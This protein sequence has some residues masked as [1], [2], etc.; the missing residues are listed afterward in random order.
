MLK[1]TFLILAALGSLQAQ[2]VIVPTPE[3][4][5]SP[6]GETW[7]NYNVMQSYEFGYRFAT[8]G[9]DVGEYRSDVNYG[10]GIRLFGTNL[11]FESK[12]GHGH[13]FDELLLNTTGLGN[14]PYQYAMLRVQKNGWY[15]YD[16]TW[17]LSDYY[18]PGLT[19]AGGLHLD[20][21]IRRL[22]DHDLTLLPQSKIRF[23]IGYSRNTD[24][25]PALSTAQEFTLDG[26]GFPIFTNVERRWNEYR[27]GADADF[28]GFQFTFQHRW[29]FFKDDTPATSLGVIPSGIPGDPSVL[30]QF[31]RAQPIHGSNPG[32]LGNLH[33]RRK[34]WGVNARLTYTN[35]KNDFALDEF[36][37]GIGSTGLGVNRQILVGGDASRPDLAGDFALS[38][39]PTS[40][41][42]FVNN[43]SI[44]N[45]RIDGDSNY[46]EFLNGLTPGA[47]IFFR[48]LGIRL[49]TNS[50]DL[51]YRWKDWIGFYGGWH[52]S[53]RQLR[54][55]EGNQFPAVPNSTV[56]NF[57]EV[58]NQMQ[59]GL[60]GVRLHPITPLTINLEG[61][62]G[63][64]T[65][66]LTSISNKNY[67]TLNGRVQYRL[68]NLQLGASYR[69]DYDFFS[70]FSLYN[71]HLRSYTANAVW[72]P[73]N[74]IAFD[75]SY[76]KL[77]NDSNT[78]LAFFA[79]PIGGRST[80]QTK[81]RSIYISNIHSGNLGVRFGL[82]KRADLYLGYSITKDTGDGRST[83]VPPGTTD[84]IQALL[85]SVQTFPLTYQSPLAR[86]SIRISPKIRWNA[87]YQYYDYEET[88]GLLGYY[89][90]F[91]AHT[92]YTSVLWTF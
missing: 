87:G 42:T 81:Y 22:Q 48:F 68:K 1:R 53:D 3:Q 8:V 69:E 92:G 38:V 89:Q 85:D 15:R 51:N 40:K 49:I 61:E 82:T 67:Q 60:F 36:A 57:Y 72:T 7:G 5:G 44:S 83:A 54:T 34:Y 33:G 14:D 29:D 4:V 63:R 52:Y 73:K 41:L 79:G 50:A 12:D 70:S 75:A 84:P 86:L 43:T 59:S 62:I 35:G 58:S 78:F 71:S 23:H 66:P 47:T 91:H 26:S 45:N 55:I 19:I 28:K 30:Q 25:G 10:N 46:T 80:L 24:T 2:Q 6:R 11:A 20:D 16:M 39:F 37:S 64:A 31:N 32:W 13:L 9:G 21:T 65:N 56:N 17:R 74:W 76:N 27:I 88:F 77:H 90:N 18:N